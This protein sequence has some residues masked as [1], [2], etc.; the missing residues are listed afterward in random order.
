MD[1]M[2]LKTVAVVVGILAV[3]GL[4]VLAGASCAAQTQMRVQS[5]DNATVAITARLDRI[6]SSLGQIERNTLTRQSG[7]VNVSGGTGVM[8][9]AAGAV[10]GLGVW[11]GWLAWRYRRWARRARAAGGKSVGVRVPPGGRERGNDLGGVA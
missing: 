8:G 5:L 10:L 1:G 3:C 6:D 7:W 11:H 4:V 9:S 2:D